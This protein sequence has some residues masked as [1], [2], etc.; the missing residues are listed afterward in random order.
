MAPT[1][2]QTQE[3]LIRVLLL[4]GDAHQLHDQPIHYVELAGILAGEG[5]VDL[6]ITRDL[7]VL[8]PAQLQQFDVLV[9]W[10][11]F[12]EATSAQVQALLEA[13]RGGMGF[14]ALHGGNA[15]F[16]NSA[17]YL[18]M[19]GSRWIDHDEIKRF[20]VH[21]ELPSHPIVEGVSDFEIEDE[22]FLIG[23]DTNRL[24]QE[25]RGGVTALVGVDRARRVR[26]SRAR[27]R[28]TVSGSRTR[29]G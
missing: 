21:I 18:R 23:A 19:L 27:L 10:T 12:L 22:L 15:T 25:P 4:M 8:D 17:E 20:S 28:P 5:G 26:A 3:T 2:G 6:R 29:V 9:N 7:G 24:L 16:W 13:V 1:I 14:V 11:T